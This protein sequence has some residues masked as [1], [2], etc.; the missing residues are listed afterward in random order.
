[1]EGASSVAF[2]FVATFDCDRQQDDWE[3]VIDTEARE[4]LFE[5]ELAGFLREEE[6][7]VPG[8][9]MLERTELGLGQRHAEAMLRRQ[10]AIPQ[11]WRKYV[12]VFTGTVWGDLAGS[13]QVPCLGWKDG[14][15]LYFCWLGGGFASHCRVVRARKSV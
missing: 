3:L 11:E 9:T 4:G 15:Y 2:Q 14:W 5:L 10:E 8:E 7:H 13:R 6:D 1:M 12:L